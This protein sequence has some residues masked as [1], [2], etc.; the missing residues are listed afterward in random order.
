MQCACAV[1]SDTKISSSRKWILTAAGPSRARGHA[2]YPTLPTPELC[3]YG[4]EPDIGL[5][6]FLEIVGGCGDLNLQGMWWTWVAPHHVIS[7]WRAVGL[8]QTGFDPASIDRSNFIDQA[9]AP[10]AAPEGP[11]SVDEAKPAVSR[12]S[13]LLSLVLTLPARV[14]RCSV[15]L[16]GRA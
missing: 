4:E 2:C 6:E 13:R 10:A 12:S 7:A 1:E 15:S 3:R 5:S 11:Q 8:T 14:H 9:L 16:Q